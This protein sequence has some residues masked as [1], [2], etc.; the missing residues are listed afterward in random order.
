MTMLVALV[1][2]D[3]PGNVAEPRPQAKPI[4]S[5]VLESED[6]AKFRMAARKLYVSLGRPSCD[7][8][9]GF[10]R[11]ALLVP[12]H[13]AIKAFEARLGTTGAAFQLA[14][15][16]ADA[17]YQRG[18]WSDGDAAFARKHVEMTREDVA[19]GLAAL[20]AL[21]PRLDR[22][23]VHESIPTGSAAFRSLARRLV[24]TVQPLCRLARGVPN[25]TILAPALELVRQF[26]A[27]LPDAVH[28][29]HY[30]IAKADVDLEQSMTLVEC[31]APSGQP[32]TLLRDD[33][34]ADVRRQ[35]A[36][37]EQVRL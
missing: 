12:E 31:A 9:A 35:I 37:L 22:G 25:E 3:T 16:R 28:R 13:A 18:C 11:K 24:Q 15:A 5:T 29:H 34:L 36:A 10:D 30:A 27:R 23:P 14:I 32:A 19:G 8:P 26:Q 6:S 17:E 7:A 21:L 4:A 20:R 2:C 33:L 1:G